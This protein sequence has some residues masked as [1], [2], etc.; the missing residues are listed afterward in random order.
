MERGA[1][2]LTRVAADVYTWTEPHGTPER[3]YTWN[4]FAIRIAE[5]DVLALVDPL[6]ASAEEVHWL[7]ALGPPTHVLLTCNWHF[8]DAE[9][10]RQRWGCR[11]FV[12]KLGLAE[13]EGPVD[14][15]FQDGDQLWGAVR[16][17]HAP[18]LN[19]PEETAVHVERGAGVLIIGD[20]L[21]GGRADLGVPDGEVGRHPNTGPYTLLPQAQESARKL[22]EHPFESVGFGHGT[23]ILHNGRAIL[24]RYLE[25]ADTWIAAGG[26]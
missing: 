2:L 13:A 17:I 14:D 26:D 19:W 20:A 18:G 12:H 1:P 16:T 5:A 3:P 25:R 10:C 24:R 11:V 15:T 22:L 23:P 21:C 8:R 9:A 6:I 4:S 7:E